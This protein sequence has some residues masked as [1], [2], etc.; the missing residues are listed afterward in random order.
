[1]G[2]TPIRRVYESAY[3]VGVSRDL[4]DG[5]LPTRGPYGVAYPGPD[6]KAVSQVRSPVGT[7]TQIPPRWDCGRKS[8]PDDD[9]P[10]RG[11]TIFDVGCDT[12]QPVNFGRIGLCC[13]NRLMAELSLPPA[14]RVLMEV[15]G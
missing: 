7:V 6:H 5:V 14:S 11:R 13:A 4:G 1:M 2:L 12:S 3:T 10:G 8:R 9:S 15:A